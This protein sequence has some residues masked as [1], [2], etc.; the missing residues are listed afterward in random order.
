MR[1]L[2]TLFDVQTVAEVPAQQLQEPPKLKMGNT[3][4]EIAL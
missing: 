1:K 4:I 3:P 2:K